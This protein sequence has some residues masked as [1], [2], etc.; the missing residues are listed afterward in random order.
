M[1]NFDKRVNRENTAAAKWEEVTNEQGSIKF[2]PLTT[3]DME[4]QT[5]QAIIEAM[6]A[7]LD[8]G[9]FG[10]TKPDQRFYHAVTSFVDK[11]HGFQVKPEMLVCTTSVVPAIVAGIKACSKEGEGVILFSPVYTAFYSCIRN[12]NRRLVDCPLNYEDGTYGLDVSRFEEL[13]KESTNRILILC[14]PHNPVGRVWSKE[15]LEEILRI[16]KR[17]DL[18]VISDEIHWD[19]ILEGKH[20]SL[21]TFEK[22]YQER[23]LICTAPSKT[24]NLAGTQLAYTIIFEDGLRKA[25]KEELLKSGQGE[26]IS[27]FGYE[28]LIAAY[29][30][31]E[32]WLAELLE[33]IKENVRLLKQWLLENVP[34]IHMTE[35]EGTY[36]V[37]LDCRNVIPDFPTWLARMR[38]EGIYFTDGAYFGQN[39]EGFVRVNIALPREELKEI[40]AHWKETLSK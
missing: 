13:A 40:L 14:N 35:P 4:F 12:T 10:Y 21:G 24:F 18:Y 20:V 38:A 36:L 25:V 30:S 3:A 11:H 39:G 32:L 8:H 23:L 1:Y 28:A 29:E 17:Y 19:I 16:C 5:C 27:V 34:E 37:W 31:G 33:Y 26:A 6:K 22:K 7:R 15:E 9:V 2:P